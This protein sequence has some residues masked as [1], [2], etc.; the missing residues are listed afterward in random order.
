M[1]AEPFVVRHIPAGLTG[2][3]SLGGVEMQLT[4]CHWAIT[5]AGLT[6]GFTVN[7]TGQ[8]GQPESQHGVINVLLPKPAE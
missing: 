6:V 1:S 5:D 3:M 4:D 7:G 2:S 8:D